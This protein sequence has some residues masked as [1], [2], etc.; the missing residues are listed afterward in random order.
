MTWRF[1]WHVLIVFIL[2]SVGYTLIH[3]VLLENEYQSLYYLFRIEDAEQYTAYLVLAQVIISIAFVALYRFIPNKER[4]L[5][6]GF[7]YAL[8][9]VFLN[10]VPTDLML[11]ATQ[12]LSASYFLKLM[13]YES[14]L[15]TTLSVLVA[16]LERQ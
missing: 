12:P 13:G 8:L 15:V 16:C 7:K 14:L 6:Q 3:N 11:Y 1:F 9:I 5:K 2:W 4:W 10:I